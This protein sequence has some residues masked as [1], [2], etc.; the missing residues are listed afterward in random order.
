MTIKP[1]D[2]AT[3]QVVEVAVHGASLFNCVDITFA[4]PESVAQVNEDNCRNSTEIGFNNVY[5]T[6]A[7]SAAGKRV[8]SVPLL[9]AASI[10]SSWIL[11]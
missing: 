4:E 9:L 8:Y 2:L 10:M 6:G 7:V 11:A 3:I 5:T 1:G